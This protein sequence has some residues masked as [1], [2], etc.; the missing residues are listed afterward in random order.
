[1]KGGR[2]REEEEVGMAVG[3]KGQGRRGRWK[4]ERVGGGRGMAADQ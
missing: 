3:Q 1:V 2:R 4:S